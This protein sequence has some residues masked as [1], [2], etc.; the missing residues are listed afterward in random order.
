LS[1]EPVQFAVRRKAFFKIASSITEYQR[2]VAPDEAV[3]KRLKREGVDVFTFIERRWCCP[4]EGPDRSWGKSEDNIAL[5]EISTYENWLNLIGKK[6]RN[7]I[8]KAEK[9][10]VTTK[11]AEPSENLAT[12]IWMIY[13]ETPIRQERAFP[14]YGITLD[15]VKR[16]I[17]ESR[18]STFVAAYMQGELV[19][20]VQLVHGDRI[21]II[22]Q[23]LSLQKHWDKAIN[24][25]LVAKT[26]EYC[27]AN[28]IRFAMYGRMGNHPTLDRFKQSNGC[29]K[30]PLTRYSVA[31]T[32][33]GRMAMKLGLHRDMKD[34]L[35]QSMKTG[36]IPYY[37][38]IS[39]TRMRLKLAAKSRLRMGT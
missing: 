16:S 6:T 39:R 26:V 5:L 18:D 32:A 4:I 34:R 7:M 8:R 23:I 12:D 9:T 22:S 15:A 36:L 35:P 1:N 11:I 28:G 19:G 29:V 3:V 13:N 20:F 14:H 24:N 38:W 27:A 25:A 37:N 17:L 2:S 31:L 10:G 30:F 33:Q 21:T